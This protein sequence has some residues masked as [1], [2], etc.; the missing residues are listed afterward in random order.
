MTI[1][2]LVKGEWAFSP[3]PHQTGQIPA[4][5]ITGKKHFCQRFTLRNA[6]PGSDRFGR[7]L[8]LKMPDFFFVWGATHPTITSGT[9]YEPK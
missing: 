5:G 8:I 1:F 4:E 3:F 7:R 6:I 2:L 9:I